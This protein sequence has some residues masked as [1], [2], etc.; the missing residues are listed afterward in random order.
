VTEG[1]SSIDAAVAE[2]DRLRKTV[3]Q[4]TS[5]Q[6]KSEEEKQIV[7]ATSLSW[8]NNHRGVI[9]PYI[10]S[11]NLKPL[12]DLYRALLDAATRSTVRTKYIDT[13]R[14]VKARLGGLQADH[15]I[16][17]SKP[18]T[19]AASTVLV[20]DP[21]PQFT[22][23]IS[24][25]KMQQILRSR[26]Q[27]CV[28]CVKS[29]APLGATVMMGGILEGL[30]LAKIN[31]LPNQVPVFTA[32]SA[33]KDRTTGKTLPLKDWMLKSFIDVAHELKW[34]T[35]TAKD[36]GVVLRDYRN[37]IHPQKEYSHGI[38]L[39][40]GD[41]EMLWNVAKGMIVQVLKP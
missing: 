13:I 22:P 1:Q 2:I 17:L 8:F 23:L 39:S 30:L 21:A 15:V 37:Y 35:T 5:A 36:I 4:Q 10:G 24:D 33:P 9:E 3:R 25:P 29:G 16:N 27:E 26:W 18:T 20:A 12:D 31:Q 7:K 41:A 14:E 38:S 6:V 40:P 11:D 19:G 32:K 34:I 28:I